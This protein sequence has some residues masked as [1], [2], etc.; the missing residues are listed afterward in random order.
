MDETA[1]PEEAPA[2]PEDE[3][4]GTDEPGAP[5][6]EEEADAE[7]EVNAHAKILKRLLEMHIYLHLISQTGI[8]GHTGPIWRQSISSRS[9]DL[10]DKWEFSSENLINQVLAFWI[11]NRMLISGPGRT[12]YGPGG[13]QNSWLYLTYFSF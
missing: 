9:F 10:C 5:Q 1:D 7:P 13:S 6:P 11:L 4:A 2:D 8:C 12:K 3:P